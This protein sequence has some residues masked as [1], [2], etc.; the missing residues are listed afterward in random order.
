[1]INIAKYLSLDGKPTCFLGKEIKVYQNGN[2][3]QQIHCC[4]YFT[5][6]PEVH[7]EMYVCENEEQKTLEMTNRC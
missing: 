3:F 7:P 4:P 1:M 6:I 2:E 5:L